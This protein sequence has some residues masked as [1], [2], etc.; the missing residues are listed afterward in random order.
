[1][2]AGSRHPRHP[3]SGSR[4]TVLRRPRH[5]YREVP[6]GV[7]QCQGRKGSKREAG[8]PARVHGIGADVSSPG[9]AALRA[10]YRS[11]RA[12]ASAPPGVMT[13]TPFLTA[14]ELAALTGYQANQFARM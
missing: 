12:G 3:P 2:L 1:M 8:P 11:R 7:R 9:S 5:L 13:T 10:A 4:T 6:A 14:D